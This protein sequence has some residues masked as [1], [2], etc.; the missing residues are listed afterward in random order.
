MN[1]FKI[2]TDDDRTYECKFVDDKWTIFHTDGNDTQK[3]A[4]SLTIDSILHKVY[5]HD[6]DYRRVEHQRKQYEKVR[7]DVA[8]LD[9]ANDETIRRMR[10]YER[11]RR[12]ETI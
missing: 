11:V 5:W 8:G 9:D 12:E 1:D 7:R 10:D 3:I 6:M 4:S 2:V